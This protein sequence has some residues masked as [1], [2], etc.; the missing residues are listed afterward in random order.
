MNQPLSFSGDYVIP[1]PRDP[2]DFYVIV[3]ELFQPSMT[4]T[5]QPECASSLE[6]STAIFQRLFLD[7]G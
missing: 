7:Y 2:V 5:S 6:D 3:G 4:I 1:D